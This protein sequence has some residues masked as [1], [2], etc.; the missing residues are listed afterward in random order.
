MTM[1]IPL[2]QLERF[3]LYR[4][5]QRLIRGVSGLELPTKIEYS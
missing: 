1:S 2:I 4:E 3:M 5:L